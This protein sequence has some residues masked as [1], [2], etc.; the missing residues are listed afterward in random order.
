M[1]SGLQFC[2]SWNLK[3]LA[4]KY[5]RNQ[6]RKSFERLNSLAS[7]YWPLQ[8]SK[9]K[10]VDCHVC[11]KFCIR[12]WNIPKKELQMVVTSMEKFDS[13]GVRKLS[14]F[15]TFPAC[16]YFPIF[17]PIWILTVLIYKIWETFRNKLKTHSV[18]EI[19][20]DLSLFE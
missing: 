9:R 15:L 16:F 14:F 8:L 1:S 17:F 12:F 6:D 7:H 19:C 18:I 4:R 11:Q 5:P 3:K 10:L 13:L 2:E 20:S